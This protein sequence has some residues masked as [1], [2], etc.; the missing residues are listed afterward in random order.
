MSTLQNEIMTEARDITN[1]T[2]VC[3]ITQQRI[4]GLYTKIGMELGNLNAATG[5]DP[6][7]SVTVN[8]ALGTKANKTETIITLPQTGSEIP[9]N[10]YRQLSTWYASTGGGDYRGRYLCLGDAQRDYQ[11]RFIAD[12]GNGP[13][14]HYRAG[15]NSSSLGT[16]EILHTGN[17][18]QTVR[19]GRV[20]GTAYLSYIGDDCTITLSGSKYRITHRLNTDMYLVT[21]TPLGSTARYFSVVSKE[22]NYC[23]IQFSAATPFDIQILKYQY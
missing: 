6:N 8:N 12:R 10:Y 11:L 9:M 15:T 22:L 21:I 5:N 13:E 23:E 4:G 18:A 3:G 7:F 20:D 1:E 19:A 14:L 17:T 2:R 16:V